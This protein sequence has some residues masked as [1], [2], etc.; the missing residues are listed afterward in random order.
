[1]VHPIALRKINRTTSGPIHGR[2]TSSPISGRT[3]SGPTYDK[4]DRITSGP[5]YNII[6]NL[7]EDATTD[8]QKE[9]LIHS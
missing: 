9:K 4:Y 5:I 6:E 1:M 2:T 8:K 7:L 3:I